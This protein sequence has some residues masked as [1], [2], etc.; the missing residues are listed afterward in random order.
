MVDL[1]AAEHGYSEVVR[2][3]NRRATT[4]EGARIDVSMLASAVSWM[5]APL[6]LA[7]SLGEPVTRKGNRHSSLPGRRASHA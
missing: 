1:G 6:A 7:G 5:V 4:G 3:C 2:L